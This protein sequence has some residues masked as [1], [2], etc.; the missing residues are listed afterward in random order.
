MCLVGGS[1]NQSA[2]ALC[3]PLRSHLVILPSPHSPSSTFLSV[4][5]R[6]KRHSPLQRKGFTLLSSIHQRAM[7]VD[8]GLLS[9]QS[10]PE[11]RVDRDLGPRSYLLPFAA[12]LLAV[13]LLCAGGKL[14]Q[15]PST[16]QA[17][18]MGCGVF[19]LFT[20]DSLLSVDSLQRLSLPVTC[21]A[22][23]SLTPPGLLHAPALSLPPSTFLL[24]IHSL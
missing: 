13:L 19:V 6:L 21:T 3:Q 16:S 23:G 20:P 22:P 14:D 2:N 17:E 4:P 7:L 1:S 24:L 11:L 18:W 8:I 9:I 15:T 10:M 12:P 5:E